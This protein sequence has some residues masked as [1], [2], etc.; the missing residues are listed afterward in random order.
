MVAHIID[1][2]C[3]DVEIHCMSM[4]NFLLKWKIKSLKKISRITKIWVKS[5]IRGPHSRMCVMVKWHCWCMTF[6]I[7]E[8]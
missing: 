2:F 5:F 7:L 8:C 4:S 3:Y 6:V 1:E